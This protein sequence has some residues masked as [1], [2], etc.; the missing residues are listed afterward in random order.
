MST[1]SLPDSW[2]ELVQQWQA[3]MAY[4]SE[5]TSSL[6]V[7]QVVTSLSDWLDFLLDLSLS[8]AV[9]EEQLHDLQQR[10]TRRWE[11]VAMHMLP[12]QTAQMSQQ[13]LLDPSVDITRGSKPYGKDLAQAFWSAVVALQNDPPTVEVPDVLPPRDELRSHLRMV[14]TRRERFYVPVISY[15]PLVEAEWQAILKELSKMVDVSLAV[16]GVSLFWL[17]GAFI[18]D[19]AGH[20]IL[21]PE[22]SYQRVGPGTRVKPLHLILG[23]EYQ[24]HGAWLGRLAEAV[25]GRQRKLHD[26]LLARIPLHR[27]T[28]QL[29]PS[30]G[31]YVLYDPESLNAVKREI[32]NRV[33]Q[34]ER[35]PRQRP[36]VFMEPEL[37]EVEPIKTPPPT[38]PPPAPKPVAEA[39]AAL[40]AVHTRPPTVEDL[41]QDAEW[42]RQK[43]QLALEENRALA[44][45]YLLASIMLD[46][47]SVDVLMTLAQ[48]ASNER[49]KAAFL[50]EAEKVMSRR[51]Q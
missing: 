8:P 22:V 33:A 18:R 14:A 34:A 6:P 35:Q 26:D 3:A 47:S 32:S 38:P 15:A 21:Q 41:K 9:R 29:F 28:V 20:V 25:E 13:I 42:L 5:K 12:G 40:P 36:A 31:D 43:G 30:A 45:K 48:L 23:A 44:K 17:L 37:E 16:E 11:T 10:F 50:R 19:Q 4:I 24:K 51:Q 1:D 27:V 49:E 7:S 39:P 46:N 2:P